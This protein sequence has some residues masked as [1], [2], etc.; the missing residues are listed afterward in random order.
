MRP[1][2]PA[3]ASL[4]THCSGKFLSQKPHQALWDWAPHGPAP[5][6]PTAGL[7]GVKTSLRLA[8]VRGVR[9]TAGGGCCS[10]RWGLTRNTCALKSGPLSCGAATS[11]AAGDPPQP[12][13][14]SKALEAV[15]DRAGQHRDRGGAPVGEGT[16]ARETPGR[17][18]PPGSR[19]GHGNSDPHPIGGPT[20]EAGAG[21]GPCALQ[22][23]HGRGAGSP[24]AQ[25]RALAGAI[26]QLQHKHGP[27]SHG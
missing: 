21:P 20:P 11:G 3:N 12:R 22:A 19:P 25:H 26:H 5:L 9:A 4:Q 8:S 16:R 7:P 17:R 24:G 23:A 13:A 10:V 15:E 27:S 18:V 2:P 6:T 14:P 1:P